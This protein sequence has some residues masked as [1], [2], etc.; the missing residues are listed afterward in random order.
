MIRFVLDSD[1]CIFWLKGHKAIEQ[2][3]IEVGLEQIAVSA[4]TVCELSYGAWKSVRREENLRALSRLHAAFQTLHTTDAVG[5]LFGRWKAQLEGQ[6][7]G[8]DDADLLIAA[9][10][11]A[12]QA[13]LI[14]NNLSH[15][16]RL[17]GLSIDN[18]MP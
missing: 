18:W 2:R 6:G 15:F 9:I 16:K 7:A 3:I 14:T 11:R 4:I 13:T 5:D 10:T 12:H 8:L 1:I 17:P